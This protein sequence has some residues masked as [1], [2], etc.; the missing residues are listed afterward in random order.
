MEERND[1]ILSRVDLPVESNG[2][3]GELSHREKRRYAK[4]KQ[5]FELGLWG[6]KLELIK[7]VEFTTALNYRDKNGNGNNDWG[8]MKQDNQNLRK[9]LRKEGILAED[10]FCGEISKKSHLLHLHGFYRLLE[11][12]RAG[13]LHS[14]L[15]P[16][17]AKVHGA[18]VV[19]V[20]DIYSVKGLMMYNVKH[21]LKNYE[22]LE[23][24]SMRLL[25]SKGWLPLG[26]KATLRMLV[27]WALEHGAK[28][29][30][31]DEFLED[32]EGDYVAF[33]WDVVKDYLFRWC[34]G[35]MITLE[36][37]EHV[38]EVWGDDIKE[39]R[40]DEFGNSIDKIIRK[41]VESDAV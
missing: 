33:A 2:R 36:F 34:N 19:W 23:F 37:R 40:V 30:Y 39:T 27:R 5:A 17:W 20:Q 21:A 9:R 15:S 10:C 38:V 11:P 16:Y 32:F 35:E 29:S 1:K 14:I 7:G 41:E 25:K 22:S 12:M 24:G 4:A 31:D 13:E 18:P 8:S 3:S 28:W 6:Q 26:W